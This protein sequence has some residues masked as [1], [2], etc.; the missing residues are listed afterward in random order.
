MRWQFAEFTLDDERRQLLRAGSPVSLEP[1][2]YELLS[3]LVVRRPRALSKPQIHDVLWPGTFVSESALAGLV[4]DLRSALG[5]DARRPRFIRTVH[6]FGYAFSGDAH[7]EGQAPGTSVGPVL[8]MLVLSKSGSMRG[9]D[10]PESA[11]TAALGEPDGAAVHVAEVTPGSKPPSLLQELAALAERRQVLLSR[12]AF[13]LA[14]A[15]HEAA[16]DGWVWLAHGPYLFEGRH[17]PVDVFEVGRADQSPLRPPSDT[18]GARRAVRPGDEVTLG[19]RPASGLPVPGRNGWTFL[20]K[21]GEGGFGEVWL[22]AHASGE[23]RVFKFCFDASRLRGL[24]REATLFRILKEELGERD[25]IAKVLDWNFDQAPFFLESEYTDGGNLTEWAHAAGGIATVPLDARLALIAQVAEALAAAHSVGVLHKDVKP[26]NVLITENA[27]GEPKARLTDFG[28]G[29]VTSKTVLLGRDFTVTGFTDTTDDGKRNGNGTRLYAAPE[30]L[31]GKTPTTRGDIYALGVMLYQVVVGDL[32]RAL[33]PGW[34]RDVTDDLLREDIGACVEGRPERRLGNAVD[35]ADR[36]RTRERRRAERE[37]PRRRRRNTLVLTALVV[38]MLVASGVTLF[39]AA[40]RGG[41]RPIPRFTRI[42]F[43]PDAVRHG[44]FSPDGRTVVYTRWG[45]RP[46]ELY[47][48]R[49]DS[50]ESRSLGLSGNVSATA[51]GEMAVILP[52]GTLARVS[53]AGGPPREI[54]RHIQEA[55]WGPDGSLAVLR[56]PHPVRIEYPV[57][58]PLYQSGPHAAGE[59][60]RVSPDG[61]RLAFVEHTLGLR[62]L[63]MAPGPGY[64][65]IVDRDGRRVVST[66]WTSIGG[67]AWTPNGTE[68]WFTAAKDSFASSIHALTLDG[69]ER[70]VSH[71]GETMYLQDIS[72]DG[73]VLVAHGR[74]T[75]EAWGRIA[76]DHAE[77]EYSW[78]D[79]TS[80]VRLSRDGRLFVFSEPLEGGGAEGRAYLRQ[81]D[82]SP[83]VPIGEGIALDISPDGKWVACLSDR[84]PWQLR[85]VPT[86]GGNAHSV[87]LGAVHDI[88]HAVF[89]S[90]GKRLVFEGIGAGLIG[91]LFI[92]TLPDGTP[93]PLAAVG[94]E[95]ASAASPDGRFVVARVRGT[96]HFRLY[97]VAGGEP[98]PIAG[99]A[100]T[101]WPLRFNSDGTAL[102]VSEARERPVPGVRIVRLDLTT[103]RKDPVVDITLPDSKGI[104]RDVDVTPDGNTYIYSYMRFLS[105]LYIIDGLR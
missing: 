23:R 67:L 104:W 32:E 34:E 13:D 71:T 81:T 63:D 36:L 50:V 100:E 68:V 80:G 56:G 70:L 87:Q 84:H 94:V 76:P 82:G 79:G 18:K 12:A 98:R 48:V 21:L 101:E 55:D 22:A 77:R 96:H 29:L 89:L 65:V 45:N 11:V 46:G 24:K 93:Q 60:L 103:G 1:K 6:G 86:V 40:G 27:R 3:L 99:I 38:L 37:A 57:G 53:I 78:L 102:F 75:A 14:R 92:L 41:A 44:R 25:D 69:H 88:R 8:R 74:V 17:E 28:V 90:D 73:R 16:D 2:A 26:Q 105:E 64:L 51:P 54:E 66:Q 85:L 59:N 15:G 4:T 20:E 19:W 58:R 95:L 72:R 61:T 83:A 42:T 9:F 62:F 97:P 30:V 33:A 91:R 49:L 35:L 7:E 5:D 31:E 52:T 39:Q 10:R 43:Q 47:S